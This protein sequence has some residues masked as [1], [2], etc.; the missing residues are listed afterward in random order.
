MNLS[1]DAVVAKLI[2]SIETRG[3]VPV[4][5]VV[6]TISRNSDGS[7]ERSNEDAQ[8]YL[9]RLDNSLRT[10][11]HCSVLFVHHVGHSE[12]DRARGPYSLMANTDGNYLVERPDAKK[13]DIAVT[14]GRMKD[15]E[16]PAPL[17]YHGEVI[18]VDAFDEKGRPVN[19]LAL[20]A[21][22]PAQVSPKTRAAL[23]GPAQRP[24]VA[25]LREH[26]RNHPGTLWTLEGL[27]EFCRKLGQHKSTA[28]SVV[29]ALTAS[30]YLQGTVGGYRFT[31][32]AHLQ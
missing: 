8:V 25:A 12:K 24:T 16:E 10:L 3:V 15:A 20:V 7:V 30:P 11:Y 21:S 2:A 5:I 27:R 19:S 1:A 17:G 13:L 29:D 14:F 23:T 6:D 22:G 18:D 28:R 4:F 9:N 32:G 26:E 31:D